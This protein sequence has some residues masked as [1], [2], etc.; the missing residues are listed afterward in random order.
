MLKEFADIMTGVGEISLGGFAFRLRF[1]FFGPSTRNF[2]LTSK[3][4]D[5]KKRLLRFNEEGTKII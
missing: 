3:E 2:A 1:A 5:I 4:R